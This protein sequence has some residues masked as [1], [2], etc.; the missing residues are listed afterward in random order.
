M[1]QVP[2]LQIKQGT[3]EELI[4][5]GGQAVGLITKEGILYQTQSVVLTSGD[6]FKRADA[7]RRSSLSGWSLRGC[8]FKWP[9]R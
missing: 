9:L 8:P 4:V 6:L 7:H 5:E 1:E 2:N 3:C